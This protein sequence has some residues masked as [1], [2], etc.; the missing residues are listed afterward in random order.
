MKQIALIV[1][2]IL[3]SLLH[4]SVASGSTNNKM[5]KL[6]AAVSQAGLEADRWQVTVKE[7][8]DRKTLKGYVQQLQEKT[9]YNA[10]ST[11]SDNS[12]KYTFEYG[13]KEEPVFGL[14]KVVIPKNRAHQAEFI[15]VIKGKQWNSQVKQVYHS[16]LKNVKN[17]YFSG[18]STTFVCLTAS[19]DGNIDGVYF[20]NK[21]KK[22]MNL[23]MIQTQTDNVKTSNVKKIVYGH[24]T[25]WNKDLIMNKPMNVQMVL[26]NK[27]TGKSALTIG[28]PILITE[29]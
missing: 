26:K 4:T 13:Q 25:L 12:V 20:F 2:I 9:D 21:L 19:I 15:A 27:T 7:Q 22:T 5:E 3:V 10:S 16:R 6:E 28:T 24:S 23:S 11:E 17:T 18:N 14:Y 8:I 29:Y 1:S